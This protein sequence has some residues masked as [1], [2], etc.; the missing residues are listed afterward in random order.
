VAAEHRGRGFQLMRALMANVDVEQRPDGTVVRMR[1][2]VGPPTPAAA[3]PAGPDDC[4]V[5]VAGDVASLH[6]ELDIACAPEVQERLLGLGSERPLTVDMTGVDYVD[7]TGVRMLLVLSQQLAGGLVI[8]A[9]EGSAP[10]RALSLS[11]LDE[12]LDVRG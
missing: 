10:R 2:H 6:G 7:S 11:R 5:E 4:R 1:R 12:V 9:P 3:S 8:V